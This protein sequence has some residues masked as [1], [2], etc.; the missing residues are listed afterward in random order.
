MNKSSS[1]GNPDYLGAKLEPLTRGYAVTLSMQDPRFDKLKAYRGKKAN[2]LV[3]MAPG[4]MYALPTD[5][6][7]VSIV[8]NGSCVIRPHES[9][10]V[11]KLVLAGMPAGLAKALQSK[12]NTLFEGVKN[13]NSTSYGAERSRFQQR[14]SRP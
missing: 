2:Q 12:L 4:P 7:L 11:A 8:G 1:I 13:G 10:D 6:L 5:T 9:K 3:C 14:T